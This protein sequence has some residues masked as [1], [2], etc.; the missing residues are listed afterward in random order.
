[1]LRWR[2][3]GMDRRGRLHVVSVEAASAEDAQALA[4][5]HGLFVTN[6]SPASSE[7]PLT[8][9]SLLD[10]ELDEMRAGGQLS[11]SASRKLGLLFIVAALFCVSAGLVGIAD[12]FLFAR[13]AMWVD[14]RVVGVERDPEI[15]ILEFETPVGRQR[16]PSRGAWGIRWSSGHAIGVRETLLYPPNRPAEARLAGFLPRYAPP[17]LLLTLGLVFL[18]IGILLFKHRWLA[19][20]RVAHIG[21]AYQDE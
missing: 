13:G 21:T 16:V 17:L 8:D 3:E 11:P 14:A 19:S 2:C 6:V 20:M 10:L 9:L 15:N 7:A 5:E 12:G 18:P 4:R 1:M